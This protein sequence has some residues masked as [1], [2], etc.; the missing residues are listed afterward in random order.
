LFNNE[1]ERVDSKARERTRSVWDYFLARREQF[2]NPQYDSDID[3]HKRGKERLI[4]PRVSETRWWNEVFGRTDAEMNGPRPSTTAPAAAPTDSPNGG[5]TPILTG[6]ETADQ[7]ADNGVPAKSIP[8]A[9]SAGMAAVASGIS[10]LTLPT[11]S[12]RTQ[13]DAD[14]MKEMKELGVEMQ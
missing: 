3:D 9:A 10:K 1:K 7:S 13:A 2:T 5:R 12:E 4:F 11:A 6:I 14:K 8:D